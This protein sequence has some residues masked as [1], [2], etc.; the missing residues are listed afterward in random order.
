MGVLFFLFGYISGYLAV[1]FA[2]ISIA[3]SLYYTAELAEEYPSIAG[4]VIRYTTIAVVTCHVL[5]L[6]DGLPWY[7]SLVGIL[8][9]AAYAALLK[10]FPFVNLLSLE[11]LLSLVAFIVS[12]F[13]WFQYF[14]SHSINREIIPTIGFF[15]VML[16]LVPC[17]IFVSVSI[18]ENIL[19]GI[20]P[21]TASSNGLNTGGGKQVNVFKYIFDIEKMKEFL[22]GISAGSKFVGTFVNS[23][24]KKS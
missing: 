7:E 2:A 23:H 12:H 1:L 18:N 13:A 3:L 9:H 5:L 10:N 8:S 11:A 17:G 21:S 20:G 14:I 22:G 4:R 15:F 19:P 16:W 24:D 6:I